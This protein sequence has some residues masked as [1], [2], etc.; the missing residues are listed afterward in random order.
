MQNMKL[1]LQHN[2]I[3]ANE[4]MTPEVK[5]HHSEN[6]LVDQGRLMILMYANKR[7]TS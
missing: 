4:L 1:K 3:D 6:L 2:E 7:N 5:S